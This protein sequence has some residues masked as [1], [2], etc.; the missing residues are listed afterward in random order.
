MS[1]VWLD[2]L[3]STGRKAVQIKSSIAF[4]DNQTVDLHKPSKPSIWTSTTSSGAVEERKFIPVKIELSP[5]G[6]SAA[7]PVPALSAA[8]DIDSDLLSAQDLRS[9]DKANRRALYSEQRETHEVITALSNETKELH[10][11][12]WNSDVRTPAA[13]PLLHVWDGSK[14]IP[15]VDGNED[16]AARVLILEQQLI[17]H[18]RII[19]DQKRIMEMEEHRFAKFKGMST[20]KS[21][22]VRV[23]EKQKKDVAVSTDDLR[24]M[25]EGIPGNGGTEEVEKL[26]A[27][28]MQKDSITSQMDRAMVEKLLA[29]RMQKDSIISQM[30]RAMANYEDQNEKLQTSLKARDMVLSQR[31]AELSSKDTEMDLLK[32]SLKQKERQNQWLRTELK[33]LG[34]DVVMPRDLH[35]QPSSR[36]ASLPDRANMARRIAMRNSPGP[37]S[38]SSFETSSL[39][40]LS[41]SLN[42]A[43]PSRDANGGVSAHDSPASPVSNVTCAIVCCLFAMDAVFPRSKMSTTDFCL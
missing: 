1:V 40:F 16:L 11:I 23:E 43:S 3:N 18:A 28:R 19:R 39:S 37:G 14:D 33:R 38:P 35:D 13:D 17:M 22:D 42:F 41:S 7:V 4:S 24:V 9:L 27:E 32:E 21:V 25:S 31:Q 20:D 29:E 36:S 5:V 26:L 30:D 8:T 6:R 10:E 34:H 2:S 12:L 15:E